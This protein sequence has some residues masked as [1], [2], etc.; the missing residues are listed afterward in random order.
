[1]ILL[2]A[3]VEFIA[4]PE[5][6][7]S[8]FQKV[9]NKE[10]SIDVESSGSVGLYY[11]GQCHKT[12]PN[13]TLRSDVKTDWCSNVAKSAKDKPW[14]LYSFKDKAMKLTGYSVRNGCCYWACCCIDDFTTIDAKAECC[15]YLN[16]F[17]LQGSNDNKTWK[18]IHKVENEKKFE[19][20]EFRT[21][22]FEKTE[23]FRYVRFIQEK[24]HPGCPFCMQINQLELYGEKIDNLFNGETE[25][26]DESVSIIGK[27]N[28]ESIE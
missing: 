24:E 23:S 8:L 17:S 10:S 7:D 25:E 21:Y 9:S 18:V 15:C 1:M 3:I 2:L 26:N 22:K 14:V 20:C 19:F 11:Y 6:K 5:R 12:F 28:R 27:F 16:S 4:F 13:E